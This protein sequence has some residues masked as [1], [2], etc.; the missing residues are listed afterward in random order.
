MHGPSDGGRGAFHERGSA[1]VTARV[2]LWADR[3][4]R[5]GA[6]PARL[7]QRREVGVDERVGHAG[8]VD[9]ETQVGGDEPRVERYDD[10]A[11]QRGGEARLDDL[12]LV[13]RQHRQAGA[14]SDAGGS[15]ETGRTGRAVG[16]LAVRPSSAVPGERHPAAPQHRPTVSQV[17]NHH[18]R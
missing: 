16:E 8:V 10:G 15:E 2:E 14:F 3:P 13:R 9:L 12:R 5:R 17:A 1:A 7:G 18:C 11:E 4:R 6:Q